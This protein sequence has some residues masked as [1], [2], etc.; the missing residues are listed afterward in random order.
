[1]RTIR[2]LSSGLALL[3]LLPTV[4]AAQTAHPFTNAWYWGAKGGAMT[5]RTGEES[6]IAPIAGAEWM[7]TRTR[8]GL[9]L[10][11][12]Q[13]YFD[14]LG[15]VVDSSSATGVRDVTMKNFRRA[16]AVLLAYPGMVGQLRPYAGIGVAL[17]LIQRARPVDG[18]FSSPGAADEVMARIE[19]R[20]SRTSVVFMGGVQREWQNL[21]LFAQ[22]TA[23]PTGGRFLLSGDDNLYIVEAG[24]RLNIGS[25]IEKMDR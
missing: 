1:M 13:G 4:A 12:E 9:Y 14:A 22:A 18:T 3:V 23:M 20:R 5:V 2:R 15:S 8:A 16:N 10:S 25:A 11:I 6:Q 7:I 17:N 24:L 19:D 21:A